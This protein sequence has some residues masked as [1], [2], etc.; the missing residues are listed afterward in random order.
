[1][2]AQT[3]YGFQTGNKKK[4]LALSHDRAGKNL[5]TDRTWTAWK[6]F[7]NDDRFDPET[8]KTLA[9]QGF[10]APPF[11]IEEVEPAPVKKKPAARKTKKQA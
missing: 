8:Q 2:A 6:S 11:T 3:V 1:M 7:T 9:A 4:I 10:W 5:P